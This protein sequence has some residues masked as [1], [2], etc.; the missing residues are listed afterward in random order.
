MKIVMAW[1]HGTD[2]PALREAHPNIEIVEVERDRLGEVIGDADAVYGWVTTDE[3]R[4]ARRLRWVH[5]PG[6]GVEWVHAC[7]GLAES[8]V[9]VTNTRGAH[10]QTI[11]ADK[12]MV[13]EAN[14]NNDIVGSSLGGNGIIDAESVRIQRAARAAAAATSA[15][16]A[17]R[18]APTASAQIEA[19]AAF[20][21]AHERPLAARGDRDAG[22]PGDAADPACV[23]RGLREGLVAGD[24]RDRPELDRGRRRREEDR[25]RVVVAGVD[26]E[27]DRA[28]R[29]PG[30]ARGGRAGHR[31][32]TIAT[33]GV[34]FTPKPRRPRDEPVR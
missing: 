28:A 32:R 34:S 4:A 18:S 26:V 8:G 19:L 25:H 16:S 6:A 29:A 9:A 2:V 23:Q 20:L 27:D 24:H 31:W 15:L 13:V 14:L 11:A 7:D 30:R 21:R 17:Y 5:S 3:L 22:D 12:S 10:A 33:R 1:T